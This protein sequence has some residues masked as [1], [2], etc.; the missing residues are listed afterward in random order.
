MMYRNL[1]RSITTT[2]G[3]KHKIYTK[4]MF[5]EYQYATYNTYP[6]SI[7]KKL[8]DTLLSGMGL[9]F[10]SWLWVIIAIAI[11]IE[12][13]FPILIRQP[14]VGRGGE[15][16]FSIKF[17]SMKKYALKE[18]INSQ[19]LENDPRITT[20]GSFL[21]KI[22]LDELPQLLNIFLGQMSF[23]GPRAL[24]HREIEINGDHQY[25]KIDDV[26]GYEAR[27]A[28][29][30]GLTGIAQIF[31]PRDIP[32]KYKFKYDMLYIEK[33]NLYTDIK[34]ILLSFLISCN[35]AWEK[36]HAKIRTLK[37]SIFGV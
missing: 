27:T 13:G 20:V 6:D 12:D 24:L 4:K 25:M 29:C 14:R 36:R 2:R 17:R 32:R 35:G 8:F 19:A 9:M 1:W 3:I 15:P 21:R 11:I 37:R 28:I 31:A 26:P 18:K 22:A 33:M 7:R 16:F 10:S 5:F 34:L 30:P 23:V